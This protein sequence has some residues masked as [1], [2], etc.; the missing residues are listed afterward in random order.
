MG[1]QFKSFWLICLMAIFL[2]ACNDTKTIEPKET[3][4]TQATP[5]S[6]ITKDDHAGHGHGESTPVDDAVTNADFDVF[7]KPYAT[8]NSE[9]VV[10]YEFFGYSC[11]HCFSF[12][13][14]MEKWMEG[15]PDYVKLIRVPVNFQPNNNSWQILQQAYFTSEAMGIV[16]KSHLK[17][18][19]AIHTDRKRFNSIED[20]AQWYEDEIGINKNEFLSTA[21]SFILDSK[22]RKADNMT[23]KMQITSTPT[24]IVNGKL[25]PSKRAQ[26]RERMMKVLD[27]LVEKEAN[28]MGLI[29][30]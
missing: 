27:F 7:D 14:Y 8:E 12:Q 15:Q 18:F 29:K 19:N 21:S 26:N 1:F 5:T 20:L 6:T 30:E 17:L 11:P 3:K 2:V 10:V 9:Q 25:R 28:T 13:P 16:E 24:I 4:T 23:I 22:L